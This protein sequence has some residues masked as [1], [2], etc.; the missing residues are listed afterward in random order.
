MA[1][2]RRGQAIL[3]V[4]AL[5]VLALSF[6]TLK[7]WWYRGYSRGS[8]TGI[9]RKVSVKGPPYCKYL[10]GEMAVQ[11]NGL[12]QIE[13]WEFSIDDDSDKNPLVKQLKD[14]ERSGD[15]VTIDYRQDLNQWYRCTPSEYFVIGVEK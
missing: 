14:A 3:G 2:G 10:S 12:A 15:R 5:L 11:G 4:V 13:I 1:V 6:V 9:V 7:L 8:R